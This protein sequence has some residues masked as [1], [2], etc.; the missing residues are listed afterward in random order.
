MRLRPRRQ[1]P[2]F[3]KGLHRLP[4]LEPELGA[5]DAHGVLK[6]NR[7]VL[8]LHESIMPVQ[9]LFRLSRD[10]RD[11]AEFV[12]NCEARVRRGTGAAAHIALNTPQTGH[13]FEWAITLIQESGRTVASQPKGISTVRERPVQTLP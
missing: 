4:Q 3:D 5:P 9:R 8:F 7:N 1:L 13:P 10:W 2:Q 6:R 12:H 11:L